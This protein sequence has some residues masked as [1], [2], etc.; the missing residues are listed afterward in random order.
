MATDDG[1]DGV[2]P[3]GPSLGYRNRADDG[4][5]P[6]KR[7]GLVAGGVAVGVAAPVLLGFGLAVLPGGTREFALAVAAAFAVVAVGGIAGGLYT[8]RPVDRRWFLAAFLLA[9]GV[10]A[11]VEGT[12]F[13]GLVGLH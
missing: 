13:A 11:A 9:V 1:N 3:T 5:P 7:A 8:L 6:G 12:C 10:T 4:P 2:P